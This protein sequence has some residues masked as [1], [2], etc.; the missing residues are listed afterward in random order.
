MNRQQQDLREKKVR[1]PLTEEELAYIARRKEARAKRIRRRRRIRAAVSALLAAILILGGC[2]LVAALMRG[3]E[4]AEVENTESEAA[5]TPD[6]EPIELPEWITVDLLPVNEFSRPG[7]KLDAM[8]GIVVHNTGN[9][10]TTAEQNRRY[11]GNV[12][13]TGETY[14]S[15]NFLIG[16]DGTIILCVPLD[17]VAY[18]SNNR[19]SDTLSI[20]CCHEDE[21][22]ALSEEAH[23]SL[24][25]LCAWLCEQYN[26]DAEEDI[27]RHYDITGKEC[28]R[29]YTDN[30][31][32][33]EA[34]KGEIAAAAADGE[35]AEE[36]A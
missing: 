18:C 6:E 27:I 34:L 11:Y 17:E 3:G 35:N 2:F 1:R 5:T 29:Y 9:P 32:A 33:W 14:V 25:K 20:E 22:G 15:S 16:I 13:K 7:T 19:N 23:D 36:E 28:P 12:A 30:P 8:H 24:V 26:L 21:S 10:G 4:D 31:E